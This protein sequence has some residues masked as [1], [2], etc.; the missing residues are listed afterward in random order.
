MTSLLQA[1]KDKE[2]PAPRHR[3]AEIDLGIVTKG[4]REIITRMPLTPLSVS[5]DC[6]ADAVRCVQNQNG[7]FLVGRTLKL[8]TW[9]TIGTAGLTG[10]QFPVGIILS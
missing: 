2:L 6:F 8:G 10:A 3:A 4:E 7:L 9:A 1:A 5:D